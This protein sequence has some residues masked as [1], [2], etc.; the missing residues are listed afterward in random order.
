MLDDRITMSS[1]LYSYIHDDADLGQLT[2]YLE[3]TVVSLHDNDRQSI[4]ATTANST[5]QSN[6]FSPRYRKVG[7]LY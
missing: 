6:S 4:S 1:P 3:T 5:L 2:N 7:Q